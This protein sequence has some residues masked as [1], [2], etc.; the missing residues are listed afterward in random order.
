MKPGKLFPAVAVALALTAGAASAAQVSGRG[1][2]AA[3]PTK[4][5]ITDPA[6]DANF[7]N[8]GATHYNSAGVVPDFGNQAGPADASAEAD[9]LSV[10]FTNTASTV[11][12]HLQTEAPPADTTRVAYFVATN[13]ANFGHWGCLLFVL[14]L[15]DP[16]EAS[17]QVGYILDNCDGGER[18]VGKHS[19]VQFVDGTGHISITVPRSASAVLGNGGV[20][21]S[22]VADARL[23]IGTPP[24][25][26]DTIRGT[27]YKLKSPR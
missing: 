4:V 10:W 17:S 8:D 5:Q 18:L 3:T 14:R 24:V 11:T 2:P 21:S 27:D 16:A 25:T 13:P 6:G 15:N 20:I 7:V 23:G 19:I 1:G 12:A 26:D 22:P 9:I